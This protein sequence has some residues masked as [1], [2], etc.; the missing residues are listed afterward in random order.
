MDFAAVILAGGRSSRMGR[1]KAWIQHDGRSLLEHQLACVTALHPLETV[2]S[3]R[4]G[5]DYSAL[6]TR[7]VLDAE[8][9]RGPLGG[10]RAAF[11]AT[12]A[13]LLLVL[14]V[15]LP[16]MT[17]AWLAQ[18]LSRATLVRG[19]V[20]RISEQWHPLAAVYPRVCHALIDQ[21]LGQ[22]PSA[23]VIRDLVLPAIDTGDVVPWDVSEPH[24]ACLVNWNRPDEAESS[25]PP[26]KPGIGNAER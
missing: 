23:S 13:P 10:I 3:G 21:A 22:R 20:P 12:A 6:R 17:A 7:V 25:D 16:R 14:A 11:A 19:V 2:I 9:D 5:I 4:P 1:D 15:D 26:P 8:P 18:L 24:R